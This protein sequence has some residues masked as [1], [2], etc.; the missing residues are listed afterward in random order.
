VTCTK[1]GRS[2]RFLRDDLEDEREDSPLI[3]EDMPVKR[4][5]LFFLANRV[6]DDRDAVLASRE[7][8][9]ELGDGIEVF[10]DDV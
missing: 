10:G 7:D 3:G 5:V 6:S 8:D 1:T 9:R 4:H 2:S